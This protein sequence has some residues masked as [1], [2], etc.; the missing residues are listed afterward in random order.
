MEQAPN[1]LVFLSDEEVEALA[2][3]QAT[4]I[5]ISYYAKTY[6]SRLQYDEDL[7]KYKRYSNGKQTVDYETNDPVLID[8]LL[9]LK[10]VHE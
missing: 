2:G 5:D 8:N 7:M 4:H 9:L 3:E 6:N 1:S 10:H